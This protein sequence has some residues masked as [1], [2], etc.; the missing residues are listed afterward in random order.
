MRIRNL[1]G[2]SYRWSQR[3]DMKWKLQ[4]GLSHSIVPKGSSL[5]VAKGRIILKLMKT[6]K[7]ES[8]LQLAPET[9][10]SNIHN[11]DSEED[12]TEGLMELMRSMYMNGDNDMK[13][14][15]AEAM[16]QAQ[17]GQIPK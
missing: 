3:M 11:K 8:W 4:I 10:K 2:H 6:N 13:R 9:H 5:K 12:S 17:S 15:I 7:H 14:A 16:T 1:N